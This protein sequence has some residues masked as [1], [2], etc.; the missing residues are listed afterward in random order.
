MKLFK[1][2]VDIKERYDNEYLPFLVEAYDKQILSIKDIKDLDDWP[3]D[4]KKE[5]KKL[6][7]FLITNFPKVR[8][9]KTGYG[10]MAAGSGKDGEVGRFKLTKGFRDAKKGKVVIDKKYLTTNFPKIKL[11]DF[12]SGS[13]GGQAGSTIYADFGISNATTFIEF[14]QALGFFV[15]TALKDGNFKKVLKAS[16]SKI[17][18]DFKILVEDWANFVDAL[19][20]IK[21]MRNTVIELVNGSYHYASA[22]GITNPYIIA[23]EIRKYYSVMLA[24]ESTIKFVKDN[25][26]DI[27]LVIDGTLDTIKSAL[28]VKGQTLSV[29]EKTGKLSTTKKI[30]VSWYQVSLKEGE[31][32][33]RMG[34]VTTLFKA[35]Y[36]PKKLQDKSNVG[37]ATT[38]NKKEE[39]IIS[40]NEFITLYNEGWFDN[41]KV[42]AKKIIDTIKQK[43]AAVTKLVSGWFNYFLKKQ[44]LNSWKT[45]TKSVLDEVQTIIDDAKKNE[46][47][48]EYEDRTGKNYVD[49]VAAYKK[50]NDLT[51]DKAFLVEKQ[52]VADEISSL[53]KNAKA[54]K[55]FRAL[56]KKRLKK[57]EDNNK[58]AVY[59]II[60]KISGKAKISRD[61]IKYNLTNSISFEII[62]TM[63]SKFPA[64]NIMQHVSDIKDEMV[65]GS[66]NYPVVKLYGSADSANYKI[67]TRTTTDQQVDVKKQFP[68]IIH[69]QSN[70]GEYYVVNVYMISK[71]D[72]EPDNS[73]Y[74]LLQ[75]NNSGAS[76]AYKIE[77]NRDQSYASLIKKFGEFS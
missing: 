16:K 71:V 61:T 10:L 4:K 54:M 41:V 32:K 51:E 60:D 44:K 42:F 33:A 12:G 46:T 55:A 22:E 77:G 52:T 74:S 25:T 31:D 18:G 75:F 30:K 37:I 5:L 59:K 50:K 38:E 2:F 73:I 72:S 39:D 1:D 64:K 56:V 26:A 57:V 53:F 17:N 69:I 24:F 19:Y 20:D 63:I 34:R 29:D 8:P 68:M 62:N 13:P 67:L 76:F 14:F 58:K 45:E 66:T 65:M 28:A 27:V 6:Y 11:K 15:S 21:K 23:D 47:K 70:T 40:L 43:I 48:E 49:R 7:T 9:E 3:E 35:W 36:L